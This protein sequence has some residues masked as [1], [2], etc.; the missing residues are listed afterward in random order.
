M[1][2]I[3]LTAV[4]DL[5]PVTE[6]SLSPSGDRVAVV[7]EE[8]D[9]EADET[10]TALYV[11][12]TDGSR[13]PHRLSR[14]SSAASPT[15]G[16]D[17]DRLAFLAARDD[18][19]GHE[20]GNGDGGDGDDGDRGDADAAGDDEID[21]AG[22]ADAGDETDDGDERIG[23]GPRPQVWV[24]DL[25][26]GGDARRV[27]AFPEGVSGFDLAPDGERLVAAARDPT[28]TDREYL[29]QR[30]ED[31][32]PIEVTRLQH[33]ADGVGWLDDVTT[34]LFVCSLDD[35][36][37]PTRLD[38]AYGA[39]AV[40]PLAGLQPAWGP[41]D[42]IAFCRNAAAWPDD[43]GAYDVFT[44]APD[45]TDAR[46]LTDGARAFAQPTWS[47][48]GDTL[49]V[50]G[51]DHENW[52]R[53]AEVFHL[54]DDPTHAVGDGPEDTSVAPGDGPE[55][56]GVAPGDGD[57]ESLSAALD[58]TV[59]REGTL[60][61]LDDE[62]VV[63]PI[64]DEAW[65][66][67]AVLPVDGEP[68]RAYDRQGRHREIEA[69]DLTG[70]TVALGLA[71][72]DAPPEVYALDAGELR[73][74]ETGGPLARVTA[75]NEDW[76]TDRPLPDAEVRRYENSDGEEIEAVTYYPADY[77]PE[78]DD[79]R[80]TVVAIHG[81]PMSYDAPT[82]RFD[83]AYWTSHGY[84]VAKPNYRGSTSYGRAFAEQLAGTR[85]ELE[86]DDVVS[87]TDELVADGVA[88]PDR[89]FCTG[90]SYGGIT[91]AH[92]VTRTD[93]FAAAAPEHGIYDFYGNFGTDDNHNWHDW[94]FGVPWENPE[95]YREI[96]SLSRVGAVDTPLLITAGEED[97]RCP[98]TQAEQLYVSVRK[99][100]VDAKLVIYTG[101]NHDV[102][103]PSR[104]TRRIEELH[105]WFRAHDPAVETDDADETA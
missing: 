43:S 36:F 32:G 75:F 65:T 68:R 9:P 14:A 25:A 6:V 38:D 78:T 3:D 58:R 51:R 8:S 10:R 54:T 1:D 17:G 102:D 28:A 83:V 64:A 30:R 13:D 88:D 26:L 18:D 22:D 98:P 24:Y 59:A 87:L 52:Y 29:R 35:E 100:G 41:T 44:I 95:T 86:T 79:P 4:H 5:R 71:R 7:V 69:F 2:E 61:W 72:P 60:A 15:W 70:D 105:D 19:L 96:S 42:R 33:K 89:L 91:T 34:Y 82:F 46:R 55:D 20:W 93:Q 56:T 53:P 85:G 84:V 31:D 23:E 90:F 77:D 27:T 21:A 48:D 39:G 67:L 104:T 66:R 97:W 74:D 73:P 99:Q 37:D 80:P 94:E 81:G 57:Y 76:A 50:V 47:P 11:A 62:T 103:D 45:G 40:E 12:P 63:V 49:A 92:V 101:E 16:P